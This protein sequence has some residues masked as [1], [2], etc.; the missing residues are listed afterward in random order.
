VR[1]DENIVVVGGSIV[2][3]YTIHIARKKSTI[4]KAGC[5]HEFQGKLKFF[6]VAEGLSIM[7]VQLIVGMNFKVL[8]SK[9]GCTVVCIWYGFLDIK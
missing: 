6:F 7:F 8:F 3:I 4:F 1:S 9:G 5:W 2:R